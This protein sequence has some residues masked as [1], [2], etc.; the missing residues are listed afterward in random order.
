MNR[1]AHTEP[2]PTL[3]LAES[4]LLDALKGLK[5]DNHWMDGIRTVL[6]NP[7]TW[8][9]RIMIKDLKEQAN[10][11]GEIMLSILGID[12]FDKLMAV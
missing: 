1:L 8:K 2:I 5:A 6:D 11:S 10:D 7:E 12:V 4:K 3:S 9:V